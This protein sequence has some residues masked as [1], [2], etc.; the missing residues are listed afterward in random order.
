MVDGCLIVNTKGK[1]I[2]IGDWSKVTSS[3][4]TRVLDFRGQLIVPGLIDLHTH[5]PQYGLPLPDEPDFLSWFERLVYTA[6]KKFTDANY[7]RKLANRFF[8]D[9]FANGTTTACIFTTTKATSTHV[10]FEEA[11]K[12]G[13]R[14]IMGKDNMDRNVPDDFLEETDRS[15]STSLDL[16]RNWHG[17]DRGR[18]LYAFSPRSASVCSRGLLRSIAEVAKSTKAYIQTHLAENLEDLSWL[19]EQHGPRVNYTGLYHQCGLLGPRTIVGHAVFLRPREL[20]LIKESRT[21]IAHCPGS[22]LLLRSG[23]LDILDIIQSRIFVGLGSDV[24]ATPRPSIFDAMHDAISTERACRLTRQGLVSWKNCSLRKN[25]SLVR[26]TLAA[27]FT[28]EN[29]F[30][31]AT[32]G[33]AKA[34]KLDGNIG[35]FGVGKEADFVV[36]DMPSMYAESRGQRLSSEI[37]GLLAWQGGKEMVSRVFIRGREVYRA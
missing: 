30:Y 4:K 29:A 8:T 18:L 7:A 22:N 17:R 19:R 33:A 10:C 15:V 12:M 2:K 24:G 21:A 13:V 23:L 5:L 37:I 31:M 27:R 16:C 35:S 36:L 3:L 26:N 6:E 20:Q 14:V 1:I 11:E 34:L 25:G 9:L 28:A 32:Q